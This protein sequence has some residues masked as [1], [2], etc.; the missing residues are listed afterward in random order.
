M[1]G[2]RLMAEVGKGKFGEVYMARHV[3]TN[4]IFALKK[5]EKRKIKEYK[6]IDQF[7]KEIRLQ[8]A[9]DHPKIVKL[10]GFFEEGDLI[11]LILEYVGGGTLFEY[12]NTHRTLSI[13]KTV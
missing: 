3:E 12:Q 6:M 13:H 1:N 2:F 8:A 4:A 7:A 11:Y 9:L 5:V 10:Y